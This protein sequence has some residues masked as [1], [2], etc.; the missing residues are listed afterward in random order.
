MSLVSTIL[1]FIIIVCSAVMAA[2]F[3]YK[4]MCSKFKRVM[5]RNMERLQDNIS[6]VKSEITVDVDQ[7]F[8]FMENK[9]DSIVSKKGFDEPLKNEIIAQS[10]VELK[11]SKVDIDR[12]ISELNE[13]L[14]DLLFHFNNP[15]KIPMNDSYIPENKIKQLEPVA[16]LREDEGFC[17][18][19]PGK[20]T[21]KLDKSRELN[22]GLN[23][24]NDSLAV[25]VN[26]QISSS[27]FSDDAGLNL[28]D[29]NH[30]ARAALKRTDT[31]LIKSSALKDELSES[32]RLI[33]GLVSEQNN[34][35]GLDTSKNGN[36]RKNLVRKKKKKSSKIRKKSLKQKIFDLKE[37]GLSDEDIA[38]RL[39][40][41]I[42]EVQLIQRLLCLINE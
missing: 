3:S 40:I 20:D 13:K 24:I 5:N 9:I 18:G 38:R 33:N 37:N 11:E 29:W 16:E 41:S 2:A 23:S 28:K 1:F 36:T 4:C 42:G 35:T 32:D 15:E 6:S 30:A 22:E 34:K 39:K 8:S 25:N 10:L 14:A 27:F 7:R 17:F 26:P 12:K 19:G 21:W 31:F